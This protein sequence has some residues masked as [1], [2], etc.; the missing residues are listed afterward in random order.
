MC[1]ITGFLDYGN[2]LTVQDLESM[3]NSIEHRGPDA[4]GAQVFKMPFVQVGLGHRR[5]SILDLSELG[6]QPMIV[7]G[8]AIVFN[9]EIYNFQEIR[10]ELILKGHSFRSNT[11][12]EVILRA[13]QEWGMDALGRFIGMFAFALFDEKNARFFLVRDRVGV[14]PLYIY[15]GSDV[16]LFGS[17]L[18]PFLKNPGFEGIL[19]FDCLAEFLKL[20]YI[21]TPH[22]IYKNTR[23]L[24]PG[25]FL[26]IDLKT[27]KSVQRRYWNVY[28]HYN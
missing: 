16:L 19:D 8:L 18:K 21:P 6:N 9:G 28:E 23:K 5:L 13:Y 7:E 15:E 25:C 2:S 4:S 14:K 3:N 17:E 24:E 1:G 22:C 12:T 11:D 26:E 20:S 27:R 10:N